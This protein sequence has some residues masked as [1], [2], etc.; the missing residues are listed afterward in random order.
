MQ[1][2]TRA[3][4]DGRVAQMADLSRQLEQVQTQVATGKR[5]ASA[6]EDPVAAVRAAGLA[7]ALAASKATLV[8][9]ER[10]SS[11]LGATDTALDGVG[12]ILERLRELALAGNNAAL[13]AADR[14]TLAGEAGQLGA[15][16]LAYANRT[17]S[18]GLALFGGGQPSGPAYAPDTVGRIVWQGAGASPA[19][20][21]GSAWI[22]GGVAGP[23][24]FE[25]LDDG[26]GV[27]TD[28][29]ALVSA[30]QASL[31]DPDPAVRATG[32]AQVLTGLE[33]ATARIADVR[34]DV[35]ARMA[36]LDD[37]TAQIER[38][39]LAR[40]GELEAAQ[41]VD[42]T[43]AIARLQRLSTVLQASQAAFVRASGL[44]LWEAL[45]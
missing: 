34:A 24:A 14:A 27:P 7:R 1:V 45:R 22:V 31:A 12:G 37:E 43:A 15:Q 11:R 8:A 10:A 26:S 41:G 39:D 18:D 25:G 5:I 21:T 36:R 33:A 19:V 32:L 40:Q 29:F 16:L 4:H 2:N 38:L 3:V 30:L 20:E 44:S 17:A 35:G 28:A 6:D 23:A 13:N 9:I 42:M